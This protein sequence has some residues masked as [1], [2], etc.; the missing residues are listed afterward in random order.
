MAGLVR[1]WASGVDRVPEDFWW[2]MVERRAKESFAV[3][4]TLERAD[5]TLKPGAFRSAIDKLWGSWRYAFEGGWLSIPAPVM[6][7]VSDAISARRA[8]DVFLQECRACRS[9]GS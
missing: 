9:H 8:V 4:E 6:P 3:I 2:S 5:G 7:P 1:C